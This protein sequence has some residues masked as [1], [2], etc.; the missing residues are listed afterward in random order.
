MKLTARTVF[1]LIALAISH[2]GVSQKLLSAGIKAGLNM[3]TITVDDDAEYGFKPGYHVGAFA[4]VKFTLLAVQ[5]EGL[6]SEQGATVKL[7]GKEMD[8][9]QNYFNIPV[10]LKYF[11]VPAVNIQAGPQIGFLSCIKSDY[12]PVIH[13]PFAEQHYTKAY[14]STD[15]GVNVGIGVEIPFGLMVDARYYLGLTDISDYEGVGET[16]NSMVQF[17]VGY[18]IFK[19]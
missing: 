12:H 6:Y 11:I 13:E 7:D 2:V 14:K 3:S 17:S 5:I 16:K 1:L 18:K 4:Q 8:F 10:T 15:F 19:F 9:K